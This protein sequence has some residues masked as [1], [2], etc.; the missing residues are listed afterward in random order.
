MKK[1]IKAKP[2]EGELF[3]IAKDVVMELRK[4]GH[5]AYCVGGC[6]RDMLMNIAPEEY[7]ITTS[8][9]PEEVASI[10]SHTVPVGVSFG[11]IL[12]LIGHYK[13]E[14]ATFRREESYSDSRRPD[15]VTYSKD[16]E[17]DV[18]RRDFTINGMLYDPVEEE[19]IDYVGGMDDITGRIIRTIGDPAERFNEDKLRLMRAVRFAARYDFILEDKTYDALTNLA[20]EIIRVS[21]ERIRDEVV[22]I[23][24][25]N[26]PGAGLTLLRGSGILKHILPEVEEMSGVEQ[27]PQFHPEGDV[28]VHTCLVLDNLYKHTGGAV[29]PELAM[30]GLLHDVGKPCTFSVSDRIRFN[31]HDKIGADMSRAICRRLKFSNKQ[32]ELIYQLVRE[33]LKFKDV[34]RMKKSTLK[35]FI[36]MPDFEEHLVLHLSDCLASHGSTEA[37]DF[38]MDKFEEFRDEEIKP[39]PLLGGKD[40]IEMGYAPGPLFSE[41]LDYVEEAQLEGEIT[42]RKEAEEIVSRKFPLNGTAN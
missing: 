15:I 16:E 36:G 33:H 11:V 10:F 1:V 23:I 31:G 37:Y 4:A 25:Q 26:N 38:I 34:F 13:F 42:N 17:E 18:L 35:R 14:V 27:P 21:E 39:A 32:I 30:A 12:V 6:T 8:A 28:F 22:K 2:F 41:I 20:P 24:S 3:D 7:D 5:K 9:T 40:L 29:S 19:V